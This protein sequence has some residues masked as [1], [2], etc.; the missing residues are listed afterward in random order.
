MTSLLQTLNQQGFIHLSTSVLD[1]PNFFFIFK[2]IDM[3]NFALR[4]SCSLYAHVSY[5]EIHFC[6]SA[7]LRIEFFHSCDWDVILI[8]KDYP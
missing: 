7:M 3:A 1:L 6:D 5:F 4:G 2:Q 8:K